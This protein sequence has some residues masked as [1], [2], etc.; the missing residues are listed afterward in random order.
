MIAIPFIYFLGLL[1]FLLRKNRRWGLDVAGTLLLVLIS[2]SAIM[3]DI[4]DIYGSYGINYNHISLPTLLLF[5]VQWSVVI[6]GLYVFGNIPLQKH[7]D[8]KVPMLYLLTVIMTVS[9]IIMIA[10]SLTDIRD[11]LLM[12]MA[13]VRNE[14]Y[15]DLLTGGR[16]SKGNYWLL[17][18]SLFVCTPFPTLALF[19][20]FYM[21]SHM[22]A[23]FLLRIGMLVSS[24]V[25]AILAIVTAGRAAI[26]YWAFD[27][28][29]VYSYFYRYLSAGVKRVL[30]IAACVIGGLVGT[31]FLVITFSRFDA[32]QEGKDPFESLYGYAGQH[33]N[34]FCTAIELGGNSPLQLARIF[35]LTSKFFLGKQFDLVDHYDNIASTGNFDA[36]VFDTFGAELFLDLGW[37][38]YVMF[39]LLLVFIINLVSHNWKV[40]EFEKVIILVIV[41]AFFARGLFAWPFINHYTTLGLMMAMSLCYLFRYKFKV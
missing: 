21:H 33:I 7:L 38:G 3:I 35:P 27:F 26:I 19:L 31:L 15:H 12:D 18:P 5:C 29:L 17:L 9:S 20:W 37:G 13:D 23:P 30:N 28:F 14:H 36:N 32:S 10:N 22:K 4:N 39:F 8:E 41:I 16:A 1:V 24:V 6:W 11:A 2:F 25:Q 40:L 34:N